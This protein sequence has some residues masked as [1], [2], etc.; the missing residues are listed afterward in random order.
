MNASG[1]ANGGGGRLQYLVTEAWV[2]AR[3]ARLFVLP[4]GLSADTDLELFARAWDARVAAGILFAAVLF[5]AMAFASRRR[6]TRVAAFGIAWFAI[7]LIPS[8]TIFPLAEVANDH[9]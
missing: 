2:W 1:Q 7:A 6:D 5:A 9:R 3:Y 8:S 4:T